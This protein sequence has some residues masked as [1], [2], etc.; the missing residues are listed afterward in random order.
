[1]VERMMTTQNPT[2]GDEPL[3]LPE[4]LTIKE[5]CEQNRVGKDLAYSLLAANVLEGVKIGRATRI[6]GASAAR[7]RASLPAYR[8]TAAA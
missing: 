4:L 6:V 8:P 7:W 5:F 3:R 2:S 1:M